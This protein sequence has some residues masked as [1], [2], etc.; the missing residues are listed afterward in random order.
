MI[1]S[2]YWRT[3]DETLKSHSEEKKKK[4]KQT[5]KHQQKN[6]TKPKTK[7]NKTPQKTFELEGLMHWEWKDYVTVVL[8]LPEWMRKERSFCCSKRPNLI[9]LEVNNVKRTVIV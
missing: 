9:E 2:Y 6:H 7:Q 8:F 4:K 5:K 1:W 3:V